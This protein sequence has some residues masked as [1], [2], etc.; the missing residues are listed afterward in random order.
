MEASRPNL[1]LQRTALC[2]YKIKA[3]LKAGIS[4]TAFPIYDR[5]AAEP[6][7]LCVILGCTFP[8]LYYSVDLFPNQ[9]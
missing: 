1:G 3:I 7:P 5:A 6:W 4:S 2:A 8:L 9:G